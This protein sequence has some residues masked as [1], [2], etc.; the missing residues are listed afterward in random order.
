MGGGVPIGSFWLSDRAVDN[1]STKLSSLMGPG[2]HGSTYGGNPLVCATALETL[3]EIR[4]KDLAANAIYQGNRIRETVASWK[5]PL[6]T[7]VRGLG[8]LLGIGL[9]PDR[10]PLVEGETAALKIVKSLI[11]KGLLTVPAGP[12]TIRLLPPLNVSD[13]EIDEALAILKDTLSEY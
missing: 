6:V 4:E 1:K 9:K 7:E 13:A 3:R 5:L 10:I 2:S 12:E 8:L 11:T